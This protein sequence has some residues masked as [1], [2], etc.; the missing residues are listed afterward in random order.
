MQPDPMFIPYM[1]GKI[2]PPFNSLIPNPLASR[3]RTI[4]ALVEVLC[5]VVAVQC[6][7]SRKRG[8]PGTTG[9]VAEVTPLRRMFL[10]PTTIWLGMNV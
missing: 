6:L 1:S 5:F 7:L 2:I 4:H 9:L 8:S 3:N 10:V